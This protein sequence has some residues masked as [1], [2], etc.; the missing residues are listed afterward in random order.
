M[1]EKQHTYFSYEQFERLIYELKG[2]KVWKICNHEIDWKLVIRNTT[3]IYLFYTIIISLTMYQIWHI[4]HIYSLF[5]TSVT[6]SLSI[7]V[8]FVLKLKPITCL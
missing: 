4:E 5:I 6:K 1:I 8:N 3:T 7:A 2:G